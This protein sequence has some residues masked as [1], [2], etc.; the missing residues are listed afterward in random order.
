MER[1]GNMTDF[2]EAL[3]ER[4][5]LDEREQRRQSRR[6]DGSGGYSSGASA[7]IRTPDTVGGRRF[8]FTN[9]QGMGSRPG[10]RAGFRRPGEIEGIPTPGGG[11]LEELKRRESGTP[12]S[13]PQVLPATSSKLS[14]PIPSVF[15]P[16]T[17]TRAGS[18]YPFSA[19]ATDQLGESTSSK[20]PLSTEQLN[21]LQARVLRA[22]LMEDPDAEALE[23]EYETER[24]RALEGGGD[25]GGAGMWEGD[26]SGVQGKMC[27]QVDESGRRVEVQV[28]P[29]LDGRGRLYDVGTGKQDGADLQ[30]GNRRKKLEKAS[31]SRLMT[32]EIDV[33][34]SRPVT[35]R[36]ICYGITR[37]T[38][39][40]RLASLCGK[41]D[42]VLGRT[43]RRTWM[44]KWRVLLLEM[45]SLR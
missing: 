24:A 5:V 7:G 9:D 28:L 36:G 15:S 8:M 17:L 22:K 26:A 30:A 19:P 34:S 11:R 35:E 37:M 10:S 18:G 2:N 14:T 33:G 12:R 3:E 21:K 44:G 43:I 27:R 23:V 20:P 4:R 39:R 13:S 29:T 6:S 42:S 16:T 45:G 1:Y 41:S 25:R 38:T 32:V 31:R 40:C